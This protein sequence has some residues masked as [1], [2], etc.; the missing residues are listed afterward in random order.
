MGGWVGGQGQGM[1]G[2]GRPQ[3][4]S[5]GCLEAAARG[6]DTQLPPCPS[7]A[8]IRGA[9]DFGGAG[10]GEWGAGAAPGDTEHRADIP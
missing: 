4:W 8:Q 2:P 5:Q 7:Q 3:S 9:L 1:E 10:P 6:L